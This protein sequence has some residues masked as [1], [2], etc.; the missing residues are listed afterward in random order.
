M[1]SK[2][3][4][5]AKL[6]TGRYTPFL[7]AFW[8][9]EEEHILKEW[10]GGAEFPNALPLLEQEIGSRLGKDV[11]IRVLNSGRAALQL[12][13]ESLNLPLGSEILISTFSCAGVVMPVIQSGHRP[14]LVDVDEQFNIR[15]ETV[16]EAYTPSVKAVVVPH[17]SG[18]WSRDMDQILGWA[19]ERE[20]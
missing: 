16:L 2:L 12:I 19:S 14:V 5:V 7:A 10:F 18:C 20:I 9:T 13:L 1:L 15:F 6:V 11:G 8:D 17:L 3:G 4:T